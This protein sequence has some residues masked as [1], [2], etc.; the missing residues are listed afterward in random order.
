MLNYLEVK[1]LKAK[2]WDN[3]PINVYWKKWQENNGKVKPYSTTKADCIERFM[4]SG[5]FKANIYKYTEDDGRVQL[6]EQYYYDDGS[7]S[8]VT[9]LHKFVTSKFKQYT[10]EQGI[11]LDIEIIV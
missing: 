1:M 3:I 2:S 8:G 4:Q 6:E 5:K 7:S 10:R 9:D 11:L